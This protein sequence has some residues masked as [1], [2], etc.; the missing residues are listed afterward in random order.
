M[1]AGVGVGVGGGVGVGVGV[2]VAR[3]RCERRVGVYPDDR[4]RNRSMLRVNL[5]D[6]G[7][8][9]RGVIGLVGV[10]VGL[11]GVI[12]LVDVGVGLRGVVLPAR[13]S[14]CAPRRR[15]SRGGQAFP[16]ITGTCLPARRDR[17]RARRGGRG[18][19]CS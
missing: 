9:L 10:G 5:V 7:V 4:R 13:P 14:T 16:A 15:A 11:R 19:S 12:G 17:A 8:G 18:V 3:R 2:G 1:G 6:V